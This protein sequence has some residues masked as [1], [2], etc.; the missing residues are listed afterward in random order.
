M[1][2]GRGEGDDV[3]YNKFMFCFLGVEG[4][5]DPKEQTTETLSHGDF[6]IAFL[7]ASVSPWLSK[8]S[9]KL[10]VCLVTIYRVH[11]VIV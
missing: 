4:C 3:E 9:C 6:L 8:E 5:G 1:G 2:E 7:R 10:F 11:A